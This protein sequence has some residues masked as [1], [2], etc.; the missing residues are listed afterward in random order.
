MSFGGVDLS[1]YTTDS[2]IVSD[3]T[4]TG[5]D[6]TATG[7]SGSSTL[8][9]PIL[10]SPLQ[11]NTT[12]GALAAPQNNQESFLE[13]TPAAGFFAGTSGAGAQ[14]TGFAPTAAPQ[15]NLDTYTGLNPDGTV[16]TSWEHSG[17]VPGD[18]GQAISGVTDP[19]WGT[20]STYANPG[21]YPT[22]ATGLSTLSSSLS[23][24][25]A[26]F[27]QMFTGAQPV[28]STVVPGQPSPNKA[29]S[30][31]SGTTTVIL[32]MGALALILLLARGSR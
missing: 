7:F 27:A 12:P 25:G 13:G 30:P 11:L 17:S 26:G 6:D 28:A 18:Q 16:D 4:Y 19:G 5:L 9:A 15:Y 24:F 22:S 2:G 14:N 29:S 21:A 31:V 10:G 32:V 3:V 20:S 8:S 1:D 23:K